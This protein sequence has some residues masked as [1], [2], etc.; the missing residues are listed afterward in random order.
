MIFHPRSNTQ[1]SFIIKEVYEDNCYRIPEDLTGKI[2]LDI[3]ANVGAFTALCYEKNAAKIYAFEPQED[4]FR[5][6]VRLF[7]KNVTK[8]DTLGRIEQYHNSR[9]LLLNSAVGRADGLCRIN[10]KQYLGDIELTGGYSCIDGISG[11]AV[12]CVSIRRV[13]QQINHDH[14]R[15]QVWIKLDCEGS[16]HEILD[17][18]LSFSHE[19]DQIDRIFGEVHQIIDHQLC[20]ISERLDDSILLPSIQEFE[21]KLKSIGYSVDIID[22]PTDPHLALFFAEKSTTS[23]K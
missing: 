4:N 11:S 1:D 22:H 19:L 12:H 6:L 14:P 16:E 10:D 23:L 2:I 21:S 15:S 8:L 20:A 13:I 17:S 5:Q 7:E 3:G 9:L 18:M